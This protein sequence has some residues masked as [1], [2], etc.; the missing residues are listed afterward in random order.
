MVM[1]VQSVHV[2]SQECFVVALELVLNFKNC[3]ECVMILINKITK[4]GI[5]I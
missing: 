1:F 3:L 5:V 2:L 4:I